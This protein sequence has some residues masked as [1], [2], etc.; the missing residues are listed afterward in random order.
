[1][2]LDILY[3][4]FSYFLHR[5]AS[6]VHKEMGVE[7]RTDNIVCQVYPVTTGLDD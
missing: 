5:D 3:N 4:F 6:S 7:F 1:M 2:G